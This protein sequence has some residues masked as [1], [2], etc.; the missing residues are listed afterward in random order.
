MER[1]NFS[2][3]SIIM[4][5]AKREGRG[6]GRKFGWKTFLYNDNNNLLDSMAQTQCGS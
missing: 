1:E 2:I 4:L 3:L 5:R 6:R